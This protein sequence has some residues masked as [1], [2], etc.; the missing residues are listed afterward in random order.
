[1]RVH[2]RAVDAGDATVRFA[3]GRAP[4]AGTVVWATGFRTIDVPMTD[5]R[6]LPVNQRGATGWT[7]LCFLWLTWQRTRARRFWAG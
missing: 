3:D 1:M 7:G 5:N 2:G 4:E 6:R